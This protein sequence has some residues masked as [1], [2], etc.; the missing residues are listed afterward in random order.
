M[1]FESALARPATLDPRRWSDEAARRLHQVFEAFE[2]HTRQSEGP[3]GLLEEI[4]EI[5][6]RLANAV[7]RVRE[8]HE[9]LL[10]EI[11]SLEGATKDSVEVEHIQHVR[12]EAL[13]LLRRISAHRQRGADLIYEAYSVDVEGGETG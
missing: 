3:D 6:P 8:E 2:R 5:A 10:A 11:A 12:E 1:E 9:D 13:G 7:K 4:V